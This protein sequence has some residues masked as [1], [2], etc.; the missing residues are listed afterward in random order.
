MTCVEGNTILVSF[1]DRSIMFFVPSIPTFL[2]KRSLCGFLSLT[3]VPT[4][5]I[6]AK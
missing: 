6:P 2:I 3:V 4:S 1:E 5:V